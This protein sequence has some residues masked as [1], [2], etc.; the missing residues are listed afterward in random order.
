MWCANSRDAQQGW[1]SAPHKLLNLRI[2]DL[3]RLGLK[4]EGTSYRLD[5]TPE[6]LTTVL[7]KTRWRVREFH[8][9]RRQAACVCERLEHFAQPR[10]WPREL[11]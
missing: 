5:P 7:C 8:C 11:I 6:R 1:T 2:G 9:P 3:Y 4:T 10:D